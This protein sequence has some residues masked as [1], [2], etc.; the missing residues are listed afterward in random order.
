MGKYD[1]EERTPCRSQ[2]VGMVLSVQLSGLFSV[3]CDVVFLYVTFSQISV[4]HTA[5]KYYE[6]ARRRRRRRRNVATSEIASKLACENENMD[7]VRLT[8]KKNTLIKTTF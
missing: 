6:N 4:V 8:D 3:T 7:L 2:R 1:Q 5:L